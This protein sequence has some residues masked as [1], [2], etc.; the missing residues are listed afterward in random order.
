M[1]R[2]VNYVIVFILAF[3]PLMSAQQGTRISEDDPRWDCRTMGNRICGPGAKKPAIY[4]G[5]PTKTT[6]KPCKRRVKKAGERCYQH[7]GKEAAK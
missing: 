6:G 1:F 5:A 4:C 7:R 2:R 3:A